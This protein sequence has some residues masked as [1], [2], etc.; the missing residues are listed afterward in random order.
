MVIEVPPSGY[1]VENR[2]FVCNVGCIDEL[3][4]ERVASAAGKPRGVDR[5]GICKC[6][7]YGCTIGIEIKL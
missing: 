4:T 2:I 6:T 1:G 7:R 3:Y 5:M